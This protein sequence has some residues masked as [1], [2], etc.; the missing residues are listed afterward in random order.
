MLGVCRN[1][2]HR[3][4]SAVKSRNGKDLPHE[5]EK[6]NFEHQRGAHQRDTS[7]V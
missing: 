7:I 3:K 1:C 5:G 6:L 4:L 2:R